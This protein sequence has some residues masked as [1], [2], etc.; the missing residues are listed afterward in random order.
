MILA[1]SPSFRLKRLLYIRTWLS[2]ERPGLMFDFA[3]AWLLQNKVLLPAASALTR[4]IG[5]IRERA[6]R[7]LWR[8]LA[9]LPDS[10][11]TEQ[12]AGLLVI[13]EGQRVSVME[14]IRKGPSTSVVRPLLTHFSATHACAARVFPAEFCRA[15]CN[16]T[17][18]PGSLCWHGFGKIYRQNAGGTA[19]GHPDRV[20]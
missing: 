3:T 5:E 13:P 12:L 17:P 7:R 18:Q 11:Q 2:N 19:A 10:W 8:R 4:L 16:S 1:I 6:S 20:C 14:Q 15:A 9:A